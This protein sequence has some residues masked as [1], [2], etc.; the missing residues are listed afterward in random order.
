VVARTT[1]YEVVAAALADAR[2]RRATRFDVR[3]QVRGT[4]LVL[5]ISDDAPDLERAGL[6]AVA[7]RVRSLPGR[8]EAEPVEGGS[9]LLLEVPCAS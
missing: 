2:R 3:G 1:A 6:G 7:E 9:R 8:I 4:G 5:E